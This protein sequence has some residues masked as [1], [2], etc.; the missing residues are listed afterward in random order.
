MWRYRQK[1][2]KQ[3]VKGFHPEFGEMTAEIEVP[4]VIEDRPDISLIPI[5]NIR[6]DPAAHW[7]DVVA[8]ARTSSSRCRCT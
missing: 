1:M 4:K 2:E 7:Y 3:T 8:R 6:F 5:E